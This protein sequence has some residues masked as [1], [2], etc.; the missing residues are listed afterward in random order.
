MNRPER[1]IRFLNALDRD[2]ATRVT[3]SHWRSQLIPQ[4]LVHK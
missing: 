2:V 1:L 4:A 3:E